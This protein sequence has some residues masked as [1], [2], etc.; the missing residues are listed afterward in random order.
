MLLGDRSDD[1]GPHRPKVV[2][3]PV[4]VVLTKDQPDTRHAPSRDRLRKPCSQPDT[5]EKLR[6]SS[7]TVAFPD[8][9][10]SLRM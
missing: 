1:T 7:V 6:L 2:V 9:R 4:M 3:V 10:D 5:V 8:D